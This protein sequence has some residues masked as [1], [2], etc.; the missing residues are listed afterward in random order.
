MFCKLSKGLLIHKV[1]VLSCIHPSAASGSERLQ[2]LSLVVMPIH[3]HLLLI[4]SIPSTPLSLN[5][6]ILAVTWCF[7]F[8][9]GARYSDDERIM[10]D[11][12]DLGATGMFMQQETDQCVV[13]LPWSF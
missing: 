9:A 8:T 7:F 1:P 2:D 13:S 3:F 12:V 5:N 4:Q 11:L 10:R 6:P